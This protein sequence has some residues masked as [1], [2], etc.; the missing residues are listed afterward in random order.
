MLYS[1]SKKNENGHSTRKNDKVYRYYN[2]M[3]IN[4]KSISL[5]LQS[6]EQTNAKMKHC[7]STP[8]SG[9]L[10]LQ[11]KTCLNQANFKSFQII[12]SFFVVILI[13]IK[14]KLNICIEIIYFSNKKGRRIYTK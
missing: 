2:K 13:R 1:L 9:L 4:L 3:Q 10:L 7:A 5:V 6:K 14:T 8:R 12:S 11:K